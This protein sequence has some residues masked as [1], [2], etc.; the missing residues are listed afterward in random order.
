MNLIDN[1]EL[2]KILLLPNGRKYS[3]ANESMLTGS[4]D[5]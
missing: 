2:Q 5:F 3:V 4:V 1:S